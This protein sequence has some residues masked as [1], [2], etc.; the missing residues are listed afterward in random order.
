MLV[1]HIG[2]PQRHL[3]LVAKAI[4][5]MVAV[6]KAIDLLLLEH[7][8]PPKWQTVFFNLLY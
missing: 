5:I 1:N 2:T 4:Y 3:D 6:K 8:G 7:S